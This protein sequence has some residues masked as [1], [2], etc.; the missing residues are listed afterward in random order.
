ML[1]KLFLDD[2]IRELINFGGW[3]HV[4]DFEEETLKEPTL[5]FLC[6]FRLTQT[7]NPNDSTA[8]SFRLYGVSHQM[9]FGEFGRH[10]GF[11][12]RDFMIIEEYRSSIFFPPPEP[13][14]QRFWTQ[15]STESSYRTNLS[16]ASKV[17]SPA[18]RYLHNLLAH[19]ISGRSQSTGSMTRQDLFYL[20]CIVE[21]VHCHLGFAFAHYV[22]NLVTRSRIKAITAGAFITR[23][24]RS[25]G[26]PVR[27]P[28]FRLEC[29]MKSMIMEVLRNLQLV[30]RQ[31]DPRDLFIL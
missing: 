6:T 27:S 18:L 25:V 24:A 13:E 8:V 12:S 23:I 1:Q 7:I 4:F 15:I 20:Y 5:E 21:R 31:R 26:V 3:N 11:Y 28:P 9:S 22:M 16:K 19:S 29:R 30:E 17:K 10:C 2:E 14:I